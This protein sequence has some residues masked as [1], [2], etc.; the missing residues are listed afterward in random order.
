MPRK[1]EKKEAQI[2]RTSA[3]QAVD[4]VLENH[5][6]ISLVFSFTL[7]IYMVGRRFIFLIGWDS[8]KELKRKI[9]PCP[10]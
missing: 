2:R 8:L 4:G 10:E 6:G 9:S 5:Q 7:I 1:F 3:L